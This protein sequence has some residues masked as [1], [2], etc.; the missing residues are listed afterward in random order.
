M[1]RKLGFL[2][3]VTTW[4]CWGFSY[5]ATKIALGSIDVW[6][7]RV[8]VM[9]SAGVLMLALA[10]AQGRSLRVPREHW[11]DLTIA[12][13]CNMAVFQ[14]AM[15]FGVH[16]FSA[17]RTAVIVYTMPLWAALFAWPLLG[18]RLTRR[19]MAALALGLIGL[20]VLM[21]QGFQGLRNAPLGALLTLVAA[22]SFGLG[23]VWMKRRQWTS[24]PTVLGGWQLLI[25]VTPVL[26]FWLL[27][28]P[29]PDWTAITGDS[30]L[31]VIYL[32]LMANVVA[33]FSWFRVVA[34]FPATVSG[35]GAMAVPVVGIFAS[36]AI[37]DEAIGWREITALALICLAL[38]LNLLPARRT[39][40][41]L[42]HQ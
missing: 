16:L 28:L 42:R 36:A 14:V 32:V 37:L 18:E 15:T 26:I 2:L 38:A 11:G 34:I 4:F 1:N 29:A 10:A 17:G 6:T 20:T 21:S 41:R 23:T 35:I 24:D 7:S 19:R 33:Y 39:W 3:L 13:M 9:L 31:A 8:V 25:G 30:W 5:P 22:I 27:A 40:V 12:A